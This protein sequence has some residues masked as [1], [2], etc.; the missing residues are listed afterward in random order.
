MPQAELSLRVGVQVMLIR[1]VDSYLSNG[2]L[3]RVVGFSSRFPHDLPDS[4]VVPCIRYPIVQFPG[5]GDRT[6]LKIVQPF[7]WTVQIGKDVMGT[8]T[9][10]GFTITVQ[11]TR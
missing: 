5:P 2:T 1:H 7:K 10:V 9:Q 11:C 4:F 3:G 6:Q 8:R